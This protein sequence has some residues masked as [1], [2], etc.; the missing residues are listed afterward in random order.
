MKLFDFRAKCYSLVALCP[1]NFGIDVDSLAS[2]SLTR[3][4]PDHTELLLVC[5]LIKFLL[6]S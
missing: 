5:D 3:Y 4:K 2:S 6:K 1:L